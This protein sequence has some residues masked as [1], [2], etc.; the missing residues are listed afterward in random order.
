VK[1]QVGC[2]ALV[3]ELVLSELL[4]AFVAVLRAL[5]PK[6]P[7]SYLFLQS[8]YAKVQLALD[9]MV[10]TSGAGVSRS[11]GGGLRAGGFID[12]LDPTRLQQMSALK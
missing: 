5:M 7:N 11:E 3:D 12:V 1:L 6:G 9:D 4:S 2:G 10:V 8:E